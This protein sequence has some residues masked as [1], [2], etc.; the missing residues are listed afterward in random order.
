MGVSAHGAE[1][2]VSS[3][4]FSHPYGIDTISLLTDE[5]TEAQRE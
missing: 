5:E 2:R 3:P 4:P 1:L